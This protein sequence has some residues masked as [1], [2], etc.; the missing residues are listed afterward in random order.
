MV[1]EVAV[2]VLVT[3]GLGSH[4]PR[5][6]CGPA[7]GSA[8]VC[9]QLLAVRPAPIL[10]LIALLRNAALNH[11]RRRGRARIRI[12][13]APAEIDPALR[14]VVRGVRLLPLRPVAFGHAAH[15]VSPWSGVS[16]AISASSTSSP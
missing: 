6:R 13:H 1:V 5:P 3:Q 8:A 4:E 9:R 16:L 12:T 14:G 2:V 7:F 11:G 10:A 15:D